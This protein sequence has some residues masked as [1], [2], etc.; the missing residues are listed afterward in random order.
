MP[1][2]SSAVSHEGLR[3]QYENKHPETEENSPTVKTRKTISV[4][5]LELREAVKVYATIDNPAAKLRFETT[6]KGGL[7]VR[8]TEIEE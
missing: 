1:T 6:K 2:P 3:E 5:K 7:N 8:L 4:P